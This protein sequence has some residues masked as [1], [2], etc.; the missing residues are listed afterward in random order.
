VPGKRKP[1]IVN[2]KYQIEGV[3]MF[4]QAVSKAM[5]DQIQAELYSAYLYLAMSAHFEAENMP[6]FAHWMQ[7]Q[8]N[9][10]MEHAMKFYGF[11]QDRGGRVVLQA[12]QQ[13]QTTF[14]SPL[15][16]FEQAYAHEQKVTA[17]INSIYDVARQENDYASQTFLNWFVDEQVEEEKNASQIV[18]TLRM[19]GDS[20]AA[21][22][23][24]DRQLGARAGH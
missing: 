22:F 13:P 5:N 18:D 23:M 1:F 3:N 7:L 9:E 19:V 16:I 14:D 4:S 2:T 6:G 12:I 24:L 8:A 15:S 10:E 21:L 17:L 11:I 20:P